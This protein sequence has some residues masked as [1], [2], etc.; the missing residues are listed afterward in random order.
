MRVTT[1]HYLFTFNFGCK[2]YLHSDKATLFTNA[3][4][5]RTRKKQTNAKT[6]SKKNPVSR[7][8]YRDKPQRNRP[9]LRQSRRAV[10]Y[11]YINRERNALPK[12]IELHLRGLYQV[13]RVKQ[14]IY[15]GRV[16]LY[17]TK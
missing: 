10:K 14:A 17:V 3:Q 8:Q 7:A 9:H 15:A 2:T 1:F 12:F 16:R 11:F 13:G 5:S 4:K 6:K